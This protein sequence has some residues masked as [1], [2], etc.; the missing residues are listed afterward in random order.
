M[1]DAAAP[2]LP[3]RKEAVRTAN[4]M[5]HYDD[6]SYGLSLHEWVQRLHEYNC[7]SN[8]WNFVPLKRGA[9]GYDN[10]AMSV[11]AALLEES[12][13]GVVY[14]PTCP[15][16][17]SDIAA[18]IHDGW[19]QNYEFWRD[20]APWENL[21]YLYIKPYAP[22]GDERR[23]VCAGLSYSDLPEDERAKDDVLAR[24]IMEIRAEQLAL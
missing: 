24:A 11:G 6:I 7:N 1:T 18:A 20:N 9:F 10:L 19:C 4:G 16:E 22:L 15:M 8:G 13:E 3:S 12:D 5:Y 2:S 17:I 23:N 14:S 21:H